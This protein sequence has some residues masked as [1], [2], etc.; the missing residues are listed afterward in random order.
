MV[1]YGFAM[2]IKNQNISNVVI[3]GYVDTKEPPEF[4]LLQNQVSVEP[5]R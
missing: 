3:D 2:D 5:N 4:E 1:G